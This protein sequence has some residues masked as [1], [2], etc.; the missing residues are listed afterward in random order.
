MRKTDEVSRISI[1]KGFTI[2]EL[3]VATLIIAILASI[4]VVAYNGIQD[5]AYAT[6]LMSRINATRKCS[7]YTT[8]SM[9]DSPIQTM[10][11]RLDHTGHALV[12]VQT[13]PQKMGGLQVSAYNQLVAPA[14]IS[15][16]VTIS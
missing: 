1:R 7:N 9:A 3:L 14:R 2:I 6:D 5:R 8:P 12:V 15:L 10:R 13:T 4:A 16:R 11:S